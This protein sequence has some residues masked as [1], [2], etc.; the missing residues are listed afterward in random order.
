M[1]QQWLS[2]VEYAREHNVSDMTVRRRIKTGKLN[3]VLKEGKYFIAAVGDA[4]SF[5]VPPVNS[6][7]SSYKE[8]VE[9]G[10]NHLSALESHQ[11]NGPT[12]IKRAPL[13]QQDESCALSTGNNP[14]RSNELTSNNPFGPRSTQSYSIQ[15]HQIQPHQI[16][17]GHPRQQAH[18]SN[19]S[20]RREA[21][22]SY[23]NVPAPIQVPLEGYETS[24]VDTRALL[25]FC[26]ASLKK[27][28]ELER[29][30]VEKFKA[31]LETLEATIA[32]KD[33]EN[34]Q[35]MQKVEDLQLLIKVLEKKLKSDH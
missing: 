24:L 9:R 34:N 3:A 4:E 5:E 21:A 17:P 13:A 11:S 23:R 33:L 28:S 19:R 27:L 22:S 35:L 20:Q 16:Q 25:A 8:P 15:S 29:R 1:A 7:P 32:T 31:K 6:T 26:D 2:I 30:Q 18:N 14:T 12:V 10:H